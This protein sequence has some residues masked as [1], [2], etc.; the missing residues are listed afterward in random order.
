MGKNLGAIVDLDKVPLKYAGLAPWEIWISE[1]QER[2]VLAVPKKN[3]KKIM[4]IFNDEDCEA[5]VIGE[6]TNNR[7]LILRFNGEIVGE[8]DMN[9][10]H[11]GIPKVKR[12]AKW[13]KTV[14]PEPNLEEKKDFTL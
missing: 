8:L 6:F 7:K 11:N 9:F 5:T 10:L 4:K 3:L 12:I 13:E 14:Y 2:M 1:S